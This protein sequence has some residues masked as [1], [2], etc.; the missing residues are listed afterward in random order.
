MRL[1]EHEHR[2]VAPLLLE[3]GL[4]GLEVLAAAERLVR[5]DEARVRP[6]HR[7]LEPALLTTAGD[8]V[9]V[10]DLK[11]ETEALLHLVAPLQRDR[12]GADDEHAVDAL[13]EHKLLHHQPGL[14]GLPQADVVGDEQVHPRQLE[15]LLERGEL[16]VEQMNARAERGLEESG[17]GGGDRAPLQGVQVGGEA[18]GLVEGGGRAQARLRRANDLGSELALPEHR[19]RAALRVVVEAGQANERVLIEKARGL[20]D[21]V[22]QVLAVADLGDVPG[23]RCGVGLHEGNLPAATEQGSKKPVFVNSCARSRRASVRCKHGVFALIERYAADDLLGFRVGRCVVRGVDEGAPVKGATTRKSFVIDRYLT[24]LRYPGGK[25][26]LASFVKALMLEN[27]LTGGHYIE[28][29]AGGAS[30]ALAL[31]FDGY[32]SH[33]H[34]NDLDDGVHAFWHSVL[35]ETE[36]L[37]RLVRN[38]RV[39]VAEWHRQRATYRAAEQASLL[40]LGFSTFF[41]NRTNRSGIISSAGMIGGAKQDGDWTLDARFNKKDLIRRIERIASERS[42]LSLHRLDALKLLRLVLPKAPAKTLTYLDPP[43]YVKGKRRL[44]ANFYEHEDHASLATAIKSSKTPW[45]VSYDDN[46]AIRGL[47]EGFRLNA[48]RLNYTARD[49][50]AGSEVMFFSSGLS[51]PKSASAKRKSSAVSRDANAARSIGPKSAHGGPSWAMP[52]N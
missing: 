50:Y 42:R 25:A 49:R 38:K 47:Y 46:L 15:R 12:G 10:E 48:Y 34:I 11:V 30:V 44:Y 36:S 52:T 24:P 23:A 13:A 5:D 17:V 35:N 20:D 1:V 45:I 27:D 31:L 8:E 39:S 6:P 22:D 3:Q 28:P 16:V 40:D 18:P 21:L 43:Y 26:K 51:I 29:F 32:V 19:E 9:A 37:C 33:V 7:N 14:D 2:L 41:L 4:Q